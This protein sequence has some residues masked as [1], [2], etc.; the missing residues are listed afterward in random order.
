MMLSTLIL[1]ATTSFSLDQVPFDLEP[2]ERRPLDSSIQELTY[3]PTLH[4]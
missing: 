2:I 3:R 4:L 1:L